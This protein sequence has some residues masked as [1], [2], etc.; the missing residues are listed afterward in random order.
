MIPID[1]L[2]ENFFQTPPTFGAY[3][4]YPA[5]GPLQGKSPDA[6]ALL[7]ELLD[8]DPGNSDEIWLAE[9]ID[10]SDVGVTR[11]AEHLIVLVGEAADS[12]SILNWFQGE[13]N[14]IEG[15]LFDDETVWDAATLEVAQAASGRFRR[16]R[17]LL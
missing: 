3:P 4:T 12:L 7:G 15:L 5:A 1:S 17:V 14:W 9:G 13:K 16:A 11:D 8:A 2:V 6:I 10:T